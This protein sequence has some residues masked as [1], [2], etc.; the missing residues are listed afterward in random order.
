MASLARLAWTQVNLAMGPF[1]GLRRGVPGSFIEPL[2]PSRNT[3]ECPN[4]TYLFR[5]CHMTCRDPEHGWT[6]SIPT[7]DQPHGGNWRGCTHMYRRAVQ[8]PTTTPNGNKNKKL[9]NWTSTETRGGPLAPRRDAPGPSCMDSPRPLHGCHAASPTAAWL[10]CSVPDRCMAA[11]QRTGSSVSSSSCATAPTGCATLSW[12]G[13]LH[14][15]GDGDRWA[16]A[17]LRSKQRD[18][19][20]CWPERRSDLQVSSHLKPTR[21]VPI[22]SAAHSSESARGTLC[23][24]PVVVQLSV[25]GRPSGDHSAHLV[26]RACWTG[27]ASL[28]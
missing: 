28:C 19:D 22:G 2:G 12:P 20:R 15:G 24:R 9:E 26:C 23:S 13:R 3:S 10:P 21:G 8:R 25:P 4:S 27:L 16:A 6:L 5:P 14:L 18:N 7:A 1:A 17:S 11:W